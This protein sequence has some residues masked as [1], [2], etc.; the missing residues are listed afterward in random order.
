VRR[1]L[2]ALA[3]T[4]LLALAAPASASAEPVQARSAAEFR[5]SVGLATHIVYF[6]TA[7][8]DWSRIV[9]KLDELGVDHLRDGTYANPGWR[10]WNE[11]YFQAVELAASHGHRFTFGMGE[12]NFGAGTLDQ[13][14]AS[15]GGRLRPATEALE[16]PNEYDLFHGGPNWVPELRTY[17][18]ELYSKA[19]AAAS[20]RE[21]PVVG[22]SLVHADSREKL[23]RLDD[24][25][26]A[27][28][29]HP[30]TGG[31]APSQAHLAR[32]KELAAR[33]SGAKPL[34]ATEV[35]FHNALSATTG[36]PP[37]SEQVA[38]SYL[39]RTY[40]EHFRAGIRRT[41]VYELIDEKPEAGLRDPEQHFGILRNDYSEKPAFTALQGMLRI[42]G[43]PAPVAPTTLDVGLGGDLTG[44]QS[45]LLRKAEGRFTLALWQ[46][47]SEWDTRT[48]RPLAVPE[49]QVTLALPADADV[50]LGRPARSGAALTPAGRTRTVSL[51]VP[52]DPLLV[53]IDFGASAPA[54]EPPA[55][56][57]APEEPAPKKP[58]TCKRELDVQITRQSSARK[59]ARVA[60]CAQVAGGV[61][62]ELGRP[63]RRGRVAKVVASTKVAVAA[64][65]RVTV[66]PVLSSRLRAR[67]RKSSAGLAV[68]VR[69][70]AAGSKTA[71]VVERRLRRQR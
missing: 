8:G 47:A 54:V 43:R 17:Q 70:R 49:R 58:T 51:S 14:I 59:P 9:R 38:A 23:G 46:S 60:V 20:L 64:D 33:V 55:P 10:D 1:A 56:A 18:R 19:K 65:R 37:V 22:P 12:P 41:F 66:V 42:L 39:L 3:A 68:R 48:R 63:D 4:A 11:R 40:L 53:E 36:Q 5:D 13:L 15:V 30:Y 24:A 62:V 61:A 25:M 71:V 35:G 50:A 26:D 45:M 57:P 31:E 2:L 67:I 28:N 16:G 6:D 69:Y 29:I 44:V 32:E 7:Y 34:W 27:G 21:L 52:A